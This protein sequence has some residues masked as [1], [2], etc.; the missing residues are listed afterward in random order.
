MRIDRQSLLL[1]APVLAAIGVIAGVV[2]QFERESAFNQATTVEADTEAD[3]FMRGADIRRYDGNGTML[4]SLRAAR[5]EHFPDNSASMVDVTINRMPGPW[6][7][8]AGRGESP[9]GLSELL[10][11]DAIVLETQL[12]DGSPIRMHTEYLQLDIHARTM[13]SPSPVRL[14]SPSATAI[15]D[16]MHASLEN[17]EVHL[18]GS[19]KVSHAP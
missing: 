3:Y 4:H 9:Q 17:R 12:D 19:V 14:E 10:L 2:L 16:T 15:A 11:Q 18:V 1:A 13:M 7:L 6:T 8:H 5:L